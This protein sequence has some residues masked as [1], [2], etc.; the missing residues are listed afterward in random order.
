MKKILQAAKCMD[1]QQVV[2]NGGPPC[3]YLE[4]EGRFCGRAERWHDKQ[5]SEM[6]HKFVSLEALLKSIAKETV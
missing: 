5:A 4:G 3:F 6:F 2:L 1:W